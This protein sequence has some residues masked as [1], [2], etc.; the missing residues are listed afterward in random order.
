M[1]G[2]VACQPLDRGYYARYHLVCPIPHT[3]ASAFRNLLVSSLSYIA[4][5]PGTMVKLIHPVT[6]LSVASAE[7]ATEKQLTTRM[8][9]AAGL[10]AGNVP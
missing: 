3:S 6:A 10:D 4:A 8:S 7:G 5:S 1:F 2:I 9:V